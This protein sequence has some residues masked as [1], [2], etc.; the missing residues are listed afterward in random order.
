MF[1]VVLSHFH[2]FRVV[3][4]AL[5]QVY[6]RCR[7]ID[8]DPVEPD[9]IPSRVSSQLSLVPLIAPADCFGKPGEV[10]WSVRVGGGDHTYSQ[11]T[12]YPL[13]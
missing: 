9:P 7:G 4:L 2:G 6:D 1:S 11:E 12:L 13:N 8:H 5:F 10:R 3:D